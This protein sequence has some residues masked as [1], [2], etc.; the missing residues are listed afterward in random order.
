MDRPEQTRRAAAETARALVDLGFNLNLAPVVDLNLNPQSPVI[1]GIERCFSADPAEARPS[2]VSEWAFASSIDLG[3]HWTA[4]V[5]SHYDIAANQPISAG[6]GLIYSNECVDVTLSASRSFTSSTIVTP[7][8]DFSLL[9]GLRGFSA[10]TSGRG[11]T[12]SC[13]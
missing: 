1:G 12:R 2:A 3:Q 8:T 4:L 6:L 10:N 5:S 11:A 9:I 7:A 13:N